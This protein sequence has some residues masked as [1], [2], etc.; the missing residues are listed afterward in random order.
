MKVKCERLEELNLKN[1]KISNIGPLEKI[2][3]TYLNCLDLT[4]NKVD[5]EITKNKDI[6]N[7]MKAKIKYFSI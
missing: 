3:F 5:V 6:C 1:N 7:N 4:G 2:E